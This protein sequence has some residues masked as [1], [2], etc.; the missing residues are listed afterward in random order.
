MNTIKI[1]KGQKTFFDDTNFPRGFNRSGEFTVKESAIMHDYG[2]TLKQLHDGILM[3]E[4]DAEIRF[5]DV[6]TGKTEALD[7]IEKAW[8]KYIRL[9]TPKPIYT[10]NGSNQVSL[11]ASSSEYRLEL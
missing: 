9:T 10:L 6:A 2:Y 7:L 5:I 4:N 1:R 3:P 11:E 8:L